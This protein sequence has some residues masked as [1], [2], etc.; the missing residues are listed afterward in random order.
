MSQT[1]AGTDQG[2][3][4]VFGPDPRVVLLVEDLLGHSLPVLAVHLRGVSAHA[5]LHVDRDEHERRQRAGLAAIEDSEVL[6]ALLSLDAGMATDWAGLPTAVLR[7]VRRAGAGAAVVER[8]AVTRLAQVPAQVALVVV[9]DSQWGRGLRRAAR[10]GPYTERVLLLPRVPANPDEL[11][12]EA[13]YLG[14]GVATPEQP[15]LVARAPF[16][17]MRF[18][19]ASWA[20]AEAAYA[21]FL[22]GTTTKHEGRGIA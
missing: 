21:Q 1:P 22:T 8:Q 6:G 13:A 16:L 15:Q 7:A 20:F 9:V 17:P 5:V 12:I 2:R 10:F 14:I 4:R 18:T 11:L 19:A 3:R